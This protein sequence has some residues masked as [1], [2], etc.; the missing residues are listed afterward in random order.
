MKNVYLADVADIFRGK[1]ITK[2]DCIVDGNIKVLFISD[3]DE[4]GVNYDVPNSINEN[5][6]VVLRYM[7]KDGDIVFSNSC[8]QISFRTAI[9]KEQEKN[10]IA[11]SNVNVIRPDK[12]KLN[13]ICLK[14]FLD[15]KTGKERLLGTT[16]EKEIVKLT[17]T[18]IIENFKIP[19]P[20]LEV[21]NRIADEILVEFEK[22][23]KTI[24]EIKNRWQAALKE[25]YK[26]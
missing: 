20:D 15:S 18:S 16:D 2:Q 26:F 8:S 22:Y 9:F 4:Y 10:Y 21:Q 25:I 14:L 23:K 17:P 19:L 13:P 12:S 7:I 3:F 11:S 5:E 1:A 6:R 24:F